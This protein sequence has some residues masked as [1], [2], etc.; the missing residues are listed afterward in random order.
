MR[1]DG[2]YLAGLGVCLGDLV[3]P[4]DAVRQGLL[5]AER[6][7]Q[8]GYETISVAKDVAPPVMAATAGRDAIAAAGVPIDAY[9]L[10]LHASTWWQGLGMH[11]TASYVARAA[12]VTAA[13]AFDVQQRCNGALGALELAATYLR[14]TGDSAGDAAL[15]TTADRFSMPSIDRW[16]ALGIGFHADGGAAAVVSTQGGFARVLATATVADNTLE[17]TARGREP[18]TANPTAEAID[19]TA[20]FRDFSATPGSRAAMHRV[21]EVGETAKKRVLKDAGVTR[22]D[23]AWVIV[24][25]NRGTRGD[26]EF[27][28]RLGF[29]ASRTSRDFGRTTGHLGAADQFAAL[30]HLRSTG[31]IRPGDLVLMIGGGAGY[32]CTTVLLEMRAPAVA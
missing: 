9:V 23:V 30:H 21:R 12:G 27:L 14:G 29:P 17:V 24:S 19:L 3:R 22:D 28:D 6:A 26:G 10:V 13:P 7:E 1:W 20:R 15:V 2:M 16:N 8:F 11:P 25:A 4:A 32:T 18:F 31:E 5:D